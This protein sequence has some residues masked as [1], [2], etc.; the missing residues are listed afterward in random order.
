M[1]SQQHLVH[2][3]PCRYRNVCEQLRVGDKDQPAVVR[4]DLSGAESDALDRAFGFASWRASS[5]SASSLR[6]DRAVRRSLP[7]CR[8]IK[9]SKAI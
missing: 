2:A 8:R 1:T 9:V 7:F 3:I 5:A 4:L 6:I